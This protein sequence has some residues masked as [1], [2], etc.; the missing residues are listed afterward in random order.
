M[1]IANNVAGNVM[2]TTPTLCSQPLPGQ[3]LQL[4]QPIM[5]ETTLVNQPSL[6]AANMNQQQQPGMVVVQLPNGM[7]AQFPVFNGT[8]GP[9]H[10]Y[11]GERNSITADPCERTGSDLGKQSAVTV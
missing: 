10:K 3:Q 11:H 2:A 5:N 7:L 9:K 6:L 8:S 4:Q 1:L